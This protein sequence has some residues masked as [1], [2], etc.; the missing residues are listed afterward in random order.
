MAKQV[1]LTTEFMRGWNAIDGE[2]PIFEITPGDG[3][4][5]ENGVISIA[6][7]PG[8]SGTYTNPVVTIDAMGRVS[9]IQEGTTQSLLNAAVLDTSD[10]VAGYTGDADA[11]FVLNAGAGRSAMY[12]KDDVGAFRGPAFITGEKGADGVNGVDGAQGPQG[13]KGETGERSPE[14]PQGQRGPQGEAGANGSNGL[15]GEQGVQGPQGIQ[16]PMGSFLT[17]NAYGTLDEDRI[18]FI[19]TVQGNYFFLVNPSGD[20]RTNKLVP[21]GI[22]GD[23]S[24]HLIGWNGTFFTDYGQLTGAEGPQGIQGPQGV[25]GERGPAGLT[26]PTG[27]Q[28]VAG[29]QGERGIAGVN[30]TNG[31]TGPQG[32]QGLTGSQGPQGERGLQGLTGPAGPTGASGATGAQGVQGERGLTGPQ[33]PQGFQGPQGVAG[34]TGAAGA[35]GYAGNYVVWSAPANARTITAADEGTRFHITSAAITAVTVGTMPAGGYVELTC[36]DGQS[37][38]VTY[39]GGSTLTMYG[40]ETWRFGLNY[41][42]IVRRNPRI[43]LDELNMSA[44]GKFAQVDFPRSIGFAQVDIEFENFR[45]DT[46]GAVLNV[47]LANSLGLNAWTTLGVVGVAQTLTTDV[48]AG[49]VCIRNAGQPIEAVSAQSV[50]GRYHRGGHFGGANVEF[51]RARLFYGGEAAATNIAAGARVKAYGINRTV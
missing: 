26:G 21:T 41:H 47:Q 50:T 24:L 49:I 11:L 7:V 10:E 31:A 22:S 33:G 12:I 5:I 36:A 1:V 42:I 20:L 48:I 38:T 28:G 25:Q 6:Q 15:N 27:A 4:S 17:P 45:S 3:V 32:P 30:G 19:R 2:F 44:L 43:L 23:M 8:V 13:P 9:A 35:N 14:G 29:I 18:T 37:K 16:G 39:G 51:N 34:P 46:A 40:G